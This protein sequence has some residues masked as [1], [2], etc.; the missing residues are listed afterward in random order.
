MDNIKLTEENF[1]LYAAQNYDNPQSFSTEEFFED[2]ERIK[3]L[4]KLAT[5]YNDDKNLKLNLVMN[6]IIILS[7]VFSVEVLNK[8]LYFKMKD[9]FVF[10][11]PFLFYLN[12][13]SSEITNVGNES[14]V[15][16]SI[17]YMDEKILTEL[18]KI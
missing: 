5:R 10:V 13:L 11:K 18:R 12:K 15:D 7:N 17:I 2:L 14:R 1:L 16:T 3:Y 4:K 6:H 9:Q 8:L